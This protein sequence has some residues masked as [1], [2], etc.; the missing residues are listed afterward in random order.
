MR[1]FLKKAGVIFLVFVNFISPLYPVVWITPVRASLEESALLA[2]SDDDGD[3]VP[4]EVS[5]EQPPEEAPVEEPQPSEDAP[6]Q[7]EAPQPVPQEEAPPEDVPQQ[8]E[9]PPQEDQPSDS[10]PSPPERSEEHTSELQSQS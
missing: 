9:A 8:E 1:V 4:D 10:P 3:G 7:E 2:F 6:Q 5:E